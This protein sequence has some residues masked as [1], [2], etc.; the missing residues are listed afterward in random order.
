MN[1]RAA[2]L[3]IG[4]MNLDILGHA[5]GAFVPGDSLPGTITSRP[6]GV[7]RNIAQQLASLGARV[8]LLCPLG[9]DQTAGVLQ[10]DCQARGI[11]LSHAVQTDF[12]SPTYLAIHGAD[13]DMAAAI[14]DMRAM[15]AFSGPALMAAL[16][17]LS[18]FD[19]CV[20]DA[21]LSEQALLGLASALDLPL[22]ADPVSAAK[23]RRLLPILPHL[24]AIKPNLMEAQALTG[25]D[26]V[27]DAARFLLEQGV[28]QVFVSLGRE[29]LYFADRHNT[30]HLSA[31]PQP[32]VSQTGAGDAMTAGLALALARKLPTALSAQAG[33]AAAADFLRTQHT[34]TEKM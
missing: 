32:A 19:A 10:A 11:G 6:G 2:L 31:P 21:N 18:G 1:R 34:T 33:I 25:Q 15:D 27:E 26:S 8:E 22:I 12:P 20:L 13:G 14:N 30:G 3:V 9:N 16:S 7:G 17:G 24:Q 28:R 4:G 23:C 5:G 29:G